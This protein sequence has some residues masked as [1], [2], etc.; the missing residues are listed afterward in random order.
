MS[1][2]AMFGGKKTVLLD[3]AKVGDR[4]L[5]TEKGKQ[6][7]LDLIEKG[8]ISQSPTVPAF[9]RRFADYIGAKYALACNNGTACL[10][11]AL[12][13]VGV[14]PGDEVIV[15]SYTFW[16]TVMPVLA[17]HAVPVFC[18]VDPQTY[19]VDPADI[20]RRI[21]PKTKAIMI[22]HVW[23]SACDM[24][25]IMAI[26]KKHSLRVIEDCSHAHGTEYHGRKVGVMGDVGCYSL[27]GSK[28]MPAG[29]G[30]ILVTNNRECFER[31][32]SLGHYDRV[33]SL[34]E[35]SDYR[36][37]ALTGLGHKYRPHPFAIALADSALDELDE[38]NAIRN[39]NA[40]K[41][42]SLIADVP[43]LV[44]QKQ[45]ADTKRVYSYHYMYYNKEAFGNVDTLALLTALSKEG[46][47]C[48][49]C[50]Y[51]RLH[52]APIFAEGG[53]YGD[54]KSAQNPVSLPV[55]EMLAEQTIMIAPRFETRCDELIEQY[56]AAIHKVYENRAALEQYTRE[57]DFTA[58]RQNMS[59]RSVAIF[60]G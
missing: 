41:L 8:L 47:T 23:G 59:G 3:Y 26:A 11:T 28:L 32:L 25:A 46:V 30:G 29:E 1:Q 14:A 36:K 2:L 13:A 52:K 24:D 49:Y 35:D 15:P 4:P 57:H 44:P 5:V 40:M 22:V 37:Y 18:D 51:G 43:V 21:T 50:G 34:P 16:A 12:F 53:A 42:E 56:A 20:E 10:D 7:V 33:P 48:G 45:Y 31:A 6:N 9:E 55:T 27:Q 58:E 17:E 54:C 19:C 60:K 38:R 39:A